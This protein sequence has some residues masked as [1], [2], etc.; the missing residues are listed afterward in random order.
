V[1]A[2]DGTVW[3]GFHR[4]AGE[5]A[6]QVLSILSYEDHAACGRASEIGCPPTEVTQ[7]LGLLR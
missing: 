2:A 5:A 4:Q 6:S 1:C 7:G 3:H